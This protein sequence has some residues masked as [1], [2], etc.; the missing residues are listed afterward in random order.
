MGNRV[1][2][3]RIV[4][5]SIADVCMI[6]GWEDAMTRLLFF[7]ILVLGAQPLLAQ[8]VVVRGQPVSVHLVDSLGIDGPMQLALVIWDGERKVLVTGA[9]RDRQAMA[10]IVALIEAEIADGDEDQIVLECTRRPPGNEAGARYPQ[11]RHEGITS[12]EIEGYQFKG[13]LWSP[14]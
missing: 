10:Q 11:A 4:F 9:S 6:D 13:K 1:P 3:T 7:G 14:Q 2:K 12:I 8:K 5:I